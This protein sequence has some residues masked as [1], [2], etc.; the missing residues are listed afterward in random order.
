MREMITV[1][2]K[3]L[4]D[5]FTSWRFM[6]LFT[7]VLVAG[8]FAIYVAAE[9]IRNTVSDVHFVFLK[10]FTT[11][12]GTLPSFLT[13]IVF[14]LPLVGIALGFDAINGEQNSGTMSR[15]LSQPIFRDAVI[16]G[17]FLAGVITI[18]IM[19][20]SIVMLVA[21]IGLR[22]IG[23]PPTAEEVIRI[24]GFLAISIVY[25]AFW[26]GLSMLFSIF[27]RRVA[28]SALASVAV[29]IF[30]L[31]FTTIL[32]GLIANALIPIG[33]TSSSLE[34][35]QNS[36]VELAVTRLSPNTLYEEAVIVLLIPGVRTLGL[37]S[38]AT[39]SWMIPNPL[40]LAQSLILV[41]P[42]LASLIA[43]TGVCFAISYIRF[44][45]EEIRST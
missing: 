11:S 20:V 21:G 5:D 45:R 7:L 44:M 36:E 14:L 3:E 10:L 30:F 13:F 31:F 25:G 35:F 1:F 24:M 16:N 40:P 22:M 18:A 2:W 32:A 42:Q 41:W 17:K 28:T 15:L 34:I 8:V 12:G 6:I 23:V 27:F 33:Q 26:M 4:S 38:Q 39:A 43:L 37:I 9:N 19:L 29:W